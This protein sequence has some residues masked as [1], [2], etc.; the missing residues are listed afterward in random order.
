MNGIIKRLMNIAKNNN[1]EIYCGRVPFCKSMSVMENK[2]C[3]IA[4]DLQAIESHSELNVKASHEL[5]HCQ[6]GSF[7]NIYSSHDIRERHEYRADKWAIHELTP[8]EEY[9]QAIQEGNT[10]VWQLAERFNVTED[11]I[12][13]ADYIYRCEGKIA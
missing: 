12:R 5:G 6:T 7:Y 11:F 2:H 10:E 13:R 8:F 3:Y 1:I 4:I 9:Q